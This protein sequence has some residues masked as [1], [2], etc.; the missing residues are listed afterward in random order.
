MSNFRD[1]KSLKNVIINN[2][3]RMSQTSKMKYKWIETMYTSVIL[4][5][6][7]VSTFRLNEDYRNDLSR[8][9]ATPNCNPSTPRMIPTWSV[10]YESDISDPIWIFRGWKR[11]FSWEKRWLSKNEIYFPLRTVRS[12]TL[13]WILLAGEARKKLR[14]DLW[15]IVRFNRIFLRFQFIK[16]FF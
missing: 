9:L 3:Y 13:Y 6:T 12:R 1:L 4:W 7:E 10:D 11:G 5:Y 8:K 14:S 16:Y 2:D 15:G